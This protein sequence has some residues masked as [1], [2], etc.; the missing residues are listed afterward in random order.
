MKTIV[1]RIAPLFLPLL[2]AGALTS[3]VVTPEDN[4][5]WQDVSQFSWPTRVGSTMV[6][7]LDEEG[8]KDTLDIVV[9]Q[10][11]EELAGARMYK[12]QPTSRSGARQPS[13]MNVHY[14]P[15]RDTLFTL[16]N[17]GFKATYALITPLEKGRTWYAAYSDRNPDTPSVRATVIE[18]YSYWKLEGK[19]YNNVVAVRYEL[20]GQPARE[21]FIRFYAQGVGEILTVHNLYPISNYQSQAAPLEKGRMV[22]LESDAAR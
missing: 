11:D 16:N 10:T 5:A 13:W 7:K 2:A 19:G 6:Y 18:R 4:T 21:E 22:L 20:L 9:K 12:L 15:T 8:F 17:I 1:A 3:C 14:L